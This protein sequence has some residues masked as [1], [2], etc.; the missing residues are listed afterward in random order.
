M[1]NIIRLTFGRVQPGKALPKPRF[2]G[3]CAEP[4]ETAR[5]QAVPHAKRCIACAK[6]WE[7]RL[8]REMAAIT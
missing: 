5:L 2:C 8:E 4:I 3:E 6:A 7:R 1:T